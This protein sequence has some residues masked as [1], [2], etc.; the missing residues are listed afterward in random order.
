MEGRIVDA[1]PHLL[2]LRHG[3]LELR[4]PMSLQTKVW[5]GGRAGLNELV[6]GRDVVVRPTVDGLGA[7]RIWVDIVRVSGRIV[8]TGKGVVEVDQGPHRRRTHVIIPKQ[9]QSQILVRHPR[10][11]P[12]ELFDVIGRRTSHGVVAVKPG[13]AQPS[14]VARPAPRPGGAV[15]SG[16]A[17][18]F[19]GAGRGAAYPRLDREGDAGGCPDA[20]DPCAPLPYLSVG[21]GVK[22]RNDCSRRASDVMVLECGCNAARFCD[23]CVECGTSPRG[24][25]VELTPASFVDLGGDLENGCFNVTLAVSE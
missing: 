15:I 9:T 14:D 8:T 1:S 24:R 20:P 11:A 22:V 21:S 17:T 18:W 13:S 7:D 25:I 23:R 6:T 3:V 16:T 10:M 19:S 4:V 2:V 12:G 5:Y